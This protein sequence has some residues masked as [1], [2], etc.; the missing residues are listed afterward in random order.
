MGNGKFLL[1]LNIEK[2]NFTQTFVE[3]YSGI[4]FKNEQQ[5]STRG[6][7]LLNILCSCNAQDLILLEQFK[8]KKNNI[9][10]LLFT[11]ETNH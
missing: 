10:I 7:I 8:L 3:V 11:I 5:I 9:K 1:I 2:L 6:Y 4:L